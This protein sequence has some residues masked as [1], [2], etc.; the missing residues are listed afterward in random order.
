[1]H[2]TD[3]GKHLYELVEKN[4]LLVTP[5]GRWT[6]YQLNEQYTT[7]PDEPTLTQ[8]EKLTPE[9]IDTDQVIYDYICENGFITTQQIVAIT[10]ITTP[11]GASVALGRL[12]K[13]GL[14][15]KERKGRHVYYVIA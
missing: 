1:M 14:V 5:N 8:V 6:T 7:Q 10:R 13:K 15:K 9:L 12:M 11:A 4:M 3:V 2:S